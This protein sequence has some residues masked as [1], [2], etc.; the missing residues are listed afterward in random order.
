MS[1]R[2]WASIQLVPPAPG[3]LPRI[4]FYSNPN[5]PWISWQ[6]LKEALARCLSNHCHYSDHLRRLHARII[7]SGLG[8]NLYLSSLLITKY[9]SFGDVHA[10]RLV[11]NSHKERP[12]K[13]LLWNSLIRGYLRGGWPRLALDV[14]REMV[15]P[16]CT[17]CEPDGQTFHLVI[18][19][20]ARLSEF[21]LGYRVGGLARAKGL[22][23]DLLVGT[24]LVGVY[25]K[26]GDLETARKLFDKMAVRDVVSWNAMISGYSQAGFLFEAMSLFKDMRFVHG[27]PPTE[28]TFVS[29]ISCCASSGSVN[30][31]EAV[32][33]H[34]TKIGFEDNQS[35]RNSLMEMYIQC[36]SLDVAADLFQRMVS[37]DSISWSTMVG[38]YVQHEQPSEALNIFQSM[39]LNTD[40]QPTRSILINVL[41][42]CAELGDW[43]QG[44]W[45]EEKYVA[46]GSSEFETD[47]LVITELIYM[48]TKCGKMEIALNYLDRSV[49]VRGDVI[50]WNAVIKACSELG[51]V[52][53]A[54]ELALEMQR[55]GINP[56][57]ATLL[58]LLSVISLIPSL[59]KG[60]EIHAHVI[61]RGFEME[62]SI[63]NSLIDMYGKCGIIGD[64]REVFN[65]I[66]RKDVVSWSSIIKAYAWNGN[67]EEAL[68][69]F[70][71]MR[72]D[73]IK[74]N[75]FTFL[76]I[77]SACSHAG[78]VEKGWEMF[79]CM[80]EKYFL[81]PDVEH[82]TCMVDMF[83]RAA[84]LHD[85]YHLLQDWMPKVCTSAVLWSTLLSS[86]R[87]YGDAAIGE[88]AA[89]HLFYLE[90]K[91]AANYLMLAVIYISAGRRED[92]NGVL[93]MLR[94]KGLGSRPGCSW[95][96]G[97]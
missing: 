61:K 82:L 19:A 91:N 77:L 92:A 57:T 85:A 67:V 8:H 39:V 13:T 95:V 45:I 42:A 29:L 32:C 5:P 27:I 40:I 17:K 7:Y 14:Y 78:L 76:A 49:Q 79:K 11:F 47:S 58:V 37:K 87:L 22:E 46:S 72:E 54:F 65:G 50:A 30:N 10:A 16:S 81:E 4:K 3:L 20:C 28:A 62:R 25:S 31:G 71:K 35:V 68:N 51:E 63:E 41:H 83:C 70:E 96:E 53:R 1:S 36:D 55:R 74:P 26:A 43:K 24:A 80:K 2:T 89:M 66:I 88:A 34:V 97:G 64:S 56:D 73:E 44:R 12:T 60:I 15:T 75:H 69:L 90:P 33:S 86:C 38:G 84:H 48:Y 59:I 93:R 52:D 6:D 9:F 21:E 18:T 23:A 94:A